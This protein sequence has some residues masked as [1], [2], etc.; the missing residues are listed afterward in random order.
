MPIKLFFKVTSISFLA[1]FAFTS[2]VFSWDSS[3]KKSSVPRLGISRNQEDG[4]KNLDSID[5]QCDLQKRQKAIERLSQE[6]KEKHDASKEAII[7]I[8]D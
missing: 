4:K 3:S 1:F 8:R 2:L 7:N 6:S 5:L